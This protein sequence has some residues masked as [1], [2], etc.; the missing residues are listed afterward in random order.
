MKIPRIYLDTSVIGGCF[1]EEFEEWSNALVADL[2]KGLFTPLVSTIV[3]DEIKSAPDNVKAKYKEIITI[4]SEV[5]TPN[6]E[7]LELYEQYAKHEIITQK[8]ANDMMHIALATIG[9]ADILV[10]W[11]FKHIVRFD[12]IRQFNAVNLECGYRTLAI[13]SPRE[14]T[15]YEKEKDI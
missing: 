15:Y 5:L 2:Y 1:D 7:A 10:S 14:V 13:H 4:G 12:K 9:D 8:Y 3:T 6:E 11:N